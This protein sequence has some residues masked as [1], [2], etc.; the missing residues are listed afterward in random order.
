MSALRV[1]GVAWDGG[2][3]WGQL[4]AGVAESADVVDIIR[5]CAPRAVQWAAVLRN[6]RNNVR[7]RKRDPAYSPLMHRWLTRSVDAALAVR[8]PAGFDVILQSQTL[9][10]PGGEA[11]RRPYAIY[12]DST[13][14]LCRG[15]RYDGDPT[16]GRWGERLETLEAAVARGAGHVFT[17][18]EFARGSMIGDYGCDPEQVTVV[19]AGV[20]V[21]VA[22]GAPP[23]DRPRAILVGVDLERKGGLEVLA[24]WPRVRA[25]VPDAELLIVG[26]RTARDVEGVRWLGR[27]APAEVSRLY[28]SST[29]FVCPTLWDPWG[30]VYHEAMAHGLP[31]IGTDR[32]AVPEIIAAGETGLLVPPRDPDAVA[33]ALIELLSDPGRAAAMGA[34]ARRRVQLEATWGAVGARMVPALRRL[35]AQE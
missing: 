15:C 1:L 27:V 35:A 6:A 14:A 2:G 31:C 13:H 18:S 28:S 11:R 26:P 20:N 3:K 8:D 5:P 25:A 12:T 16:P 22:E 33:A 17:M 24:A 4:Y 10:T 30:L 32:F 34:E 29:V 21:A 7:E 9:F 23:R 19:G